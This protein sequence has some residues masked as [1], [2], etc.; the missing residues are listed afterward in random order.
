MKNC[1]YKIRQIQTKSWMKV[2]KQISEQYWEYEKLF[3]KL[4]EN[5]ALSEYK[6]WNHKISLKKEVTSEKLLIYQLL[7]EKLQKLQN[8]FNNNL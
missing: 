1:K 2:K 5:Q 6:S 7:L 8:Y 3:M 4:S